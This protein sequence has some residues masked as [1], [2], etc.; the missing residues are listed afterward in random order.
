M[1]RQKIVDT[2]RGY[3]G[4]PF[5]HQ[6]RLPGVGLDCAGV[7][8]CALQQ[9]GFVIDDVRGYGRLPHNGMLLAAVQKYCS[10]IALGDVRPAD[11]LLFR[12]RREPQHL[13]M[14]VDTDPVMMVHALADLAIH[15]TVEH[16][17]DDYWL[18]KL[19]ACYRIEERLCRQE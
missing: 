1:D 10:K 4:T 14:V 2:V 8:V 19:V 6:G 13:A 12:P 15:R 3:I 18:P 5:V 16:I 11:I 17:L 7:I 9:Q